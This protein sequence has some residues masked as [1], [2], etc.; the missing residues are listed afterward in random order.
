ME[1]FGKLIYLDV[2]K[3]GSTYVHQ[4]L[5][6]N[7][8]LP[9]VERRQHM[10]CI[11][12]PP[13]G[14]VAFIT[15]RHPMQQYLSLF[16]FGC[17]GKGALRSR[18]RAY[19]AELYEPTTRGFERWLRVMLDESLAPLLGENYQC[20]DAGVIGFQ[21]FRFL[22]LSFADPEKQLSGLRQYADV[23]L[24]YNAHRVHQHVMRNEYLNQELAQAVDGFLAPFIKDGP[25]AKSFLATARKVNA[26]REFDIDLAAISRST[27]ALL[28]TKE[29]FLLESFYQ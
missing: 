10:P 18:L 26:T 2:Q 16:K 13:D 25:T 15:C 8:N 7:L 22:L 6:E 17:E 1:D 9:L 11:S 5:M 14:T 4:F 24:M 28:E 19:A 27:L 12:R 20:V 21:T 29:R 3:T 23:Q